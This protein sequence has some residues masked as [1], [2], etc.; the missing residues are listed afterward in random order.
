MRYSNNIPEN[1][2]P[3]Y[4]SQIL[5]EHINEQGSVSLSTI[6]NLFDQAAEVILRRISNR[7]EV[8]AEKS[9]HL[10]KIELFEDLEKY[11]K[12]AIETQIRK[13]DKKS[14][15]LAFVMHKIPASG[16]WVKTSKAI[17]SYDLQKLLAAA[18]VA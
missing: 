7:Y 8:R 17:Y 6:F 9:N 16:A 14:I 4:I 3:N 15:Q 18:N 12:I 5:P 2:T 10:L 13:F 1:K 11:D